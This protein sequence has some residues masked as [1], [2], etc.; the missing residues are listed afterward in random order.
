[1]AGFYVQKTGYSIIILPL[2]F[3]YVSVAANDCLP[4][5][6]SKQRRMIHIQL[7]NQ[8]LPAPLQWSE[9]LGVT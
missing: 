6:N 9:H 1:M 5:K 7:S 3:A 8:V 2:L 4:L